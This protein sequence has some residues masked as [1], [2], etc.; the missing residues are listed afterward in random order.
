MFGTG[1]DVERLGLMV[2][3]GQPKT[4]A[5]YIQATGRVGRQMGG[6]VV[7]FLK[8]ARPRDLDHYEFFT[9]YHRS[10]H[11]NVEPITVYPFSP[12][13][14]ERGLGPLAVV[15][16]RNAGTLEGV[17]VPP[18][19]AVERWTSSDVAT[20]TGSRLMANRKTSAEVRKII[21]LLAA[22]ASDQPEGRRPKAAEFDQLVSSGVDRWELFAKRF[23][24][25]LVYAESVFRR[26]ATRHVVLGDPG[27]SPEQQ[28]FR[29]APQSL[30]EVE[31]T[32]T[33][34]D[35]G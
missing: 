24:D 22:R 14:M 30:R 10:L 11:R 2:V 20:A 21:E 28:V 9:G 5:N 4:T 29:N 8:A 31:S 16:L 32:V 35:E 15:L 13:A 19:W 34:D 25:E 23:D 1:V 17:G 33:F 3:D 12:R 18:D 27:H 6:L 7:T 26:Q